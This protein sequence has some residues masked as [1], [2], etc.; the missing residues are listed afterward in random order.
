MLESAKL[1]NVALEI[2]HPIVPTSKVALE[3]SVESPL[4]QDE[5]ELTQ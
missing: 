1:S 3:V 5:P 4:I 2:S